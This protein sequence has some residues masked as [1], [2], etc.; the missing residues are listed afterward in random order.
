MKEATNWQSFALGLLF[1]I[2]PF[3]T[4]AQISTADSLVYVYYYGQINK[5]EHSDSIF[6]Y[7]DTIVDFSK[8]KKHLDK[9]IEALFFK[10]GYA[11]ENDQLNIAKNSFHQISNSINKIKDNKKKHS[12][13]FDKLVLKNHYYRQIGKKSQA[14]EEMEII[15][16]DLES[17][18]TNTANDSSNLYYT[19][20]QLGQ[21]HSE[22][23]NYDEAINYYKR[24]RDFTRNPKA[25]YGYIGVAYRN[26]KEYEKAK[27]YIKE[28]IES[29]IEREKNNQPFA[30]SLLSADYRNLSNILVKEGNWDKA[31]QYLLKSRNYISSNNSAYPY[32]YIQEG[33]IHLAKKEYQNALNSINE[34]LRLKKKS[35]Q[36]DKNVQFV[37]FYSSLGDVH[38]EKG[39]LLK[40]LDYFQLA[41]INLV[42]NF[43]DT[44]FSENPLPD[45][46]DN[47]KS[48][49]EIL[50]KK[51]KALVILSEEE[52]ALS[53][54]DQKY[55]KLAYKTAKTAIA[56][57]DNI[58]VD[59]FSEADKQFL[60]EQSYPIYKQAIQL[61]YNRGEIEKA[62]QYT[63]KYKAV[64]LFEAMKLT[65]AEAFADLDEDILIQKFEL[66]KKLINCQNSML[67]TNSAIEKEKYSK[68]FFKLKKEFELLLNKMKENSQFKFALQEITIASSLEIKNNVLFPNQSLLEFFVSEEYILGFLIS[69]EYDSLVVKKI[70]FSKELKYAI[71]HINDHIY[72]IEN[73]YIQEAQLIYQQL[74]DPF[75]ENTG[76]PESLVLIPDGILWNIPYRALITESVK[77]EAQPNFKKLKYLGIQVALSRCFSASTYATM[78]RSTQK[79]DWDQ[80][81]LAY[82]PPFK[83]IINK[84]GGD[85]RGELMPLY[86]TKEEIIDI[87]AKF[88]QP[89]LIYDTLAIKDHFLNRIFQFKYKIIHFA[90]HGIVDKEHPERSYIAFSNLVHNGGNDQS[91]KL[92]LNELYN[93]FI[94]SEMVVLSACESGIGKMY[95]GEGAIS[96]ARGF[97]Y[98][99]TKSVIT[100]LWRI[101]DKASCQIM[102][103][104]Y[105]ELMQGNR[106]DIALRNANESYIQNF[107]IDNDRAHPKY[108]ASF[109]AIGN[110][111]PIQ[112]SC[113]SIK[114]IAF[115]LFII[116][117][118]TLLY[119]LF[120][121]FRKG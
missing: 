68:Q 8:R 23:G 99:G 3:A 80:E 94:P 96:I 26:K 53:K 86:N 27:F 58:R 14:L 42:E 82:A 72:F 85:D 100:T 89:E 38:F 44:D 108:W 118:L 116:L 9:T 81:L 111:D 106:K 76:F 1:F 11:I 115:Y 79:T 69:P 22:E 47:R 121:R 43:N 13:N 50:N 75:F 29:F 87:G 113:F 37:K 54:E 88:N 56:L 70:P 31:L 36:I 78:N 62:F 101:P 6:F 49:L 105:S 10:I 90:T 20:L 95:K 39:T 64:N 73:A 51:I 2:L 74:I 83:P 19:Y 117:S 91:F 65:Q 92:G 17:D 60:M 77:N 15:I 67:T 7:Y 55:T 33:N 32:T 109:T 30:P 57:I 24:A 102:K 104:F 84:K 119:K 61:A 28:E 4:S 120:K 98:A 114:R 34:G 41:M 46:L 93:M 110:M 25:F 45:Y 71:E 59:Y 21:I 52:V 40:A 97:I 112:V 5:A 48:L 107:D 16:K 12:L 66:K 63:D 103:N 18:H 35:L